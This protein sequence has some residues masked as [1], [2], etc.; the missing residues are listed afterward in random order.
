MH[1]SSLARRLFIT[2]TV[3]S[4]V[5]LVIVGLL[6][7][8][9]YRASVE[10][11]FDRRLN[12]YLKTIVADVATTAKDVL[13][14]PALGE[15]LFEQPLSGWYWQIN[16]IGGDSASQKSSRSTPAT[17][18]PA[19]DVA[20]VEN[21]GG[22]REGYVEG[23]D[24]QHLRV[25]ERIVDL[26][27]DGRYLVSVAGD[28]LEI[29]DD[30]EDFND[31]LFVTFGFLGLAFVLT[32]WF[33]VRFGLRPLA[34]ISKALSAIRSGRAER[35]E[36]KFPAEIAPLASEVNALLDSNREIVDRARTH[37]GNLAHALKTPLSVL[38]NEAATRDDPVAEKVREQV[39]L[40]REQVQHH[41]ERAKIAARV[42]VVGTVSEVS[43]VVAGLVR[44]MRKIHRDREIT[45]ETHLIEEVNFHGEQQDLEEML[46]NLVDNA[47]KWAS[48]RVEVGAFTEKATTPGER[49]YFHVMIDDDGPG[50]PSEM[51]QQFPFRGRKLDESKSGS[52]LGLSI[53]MDLATLYGGKLLLGNAP[54]GGLRAELV[55]PAA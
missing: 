29:N 14:E 49:T 9:L 8:T 3:V 4:V 26:G 51:H 46:G 24:G 23:P 20:T 33:Q 34:H 13:P 5:I 39:S 41:L 38:L 10:R 44:T 17:G 28:S 36:G 40:M 47:C 37:V 52:G 32:V 54:I 18:L 27:E 11:S 22:Y 6:L 50:L 31:A 2:A 16:R 19:L 35:L 30:S 43:P 12:V 7:S 45:I 53:V 55:L 1:A 48:S 42:A 21:L 25:V 15:P